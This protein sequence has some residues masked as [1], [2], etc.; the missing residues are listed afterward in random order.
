MREVRVHPVYKGID[1][2]ALWQGLPTLYLMVILGTAALVSTVAPIAMA[3][4]TGSILF[5]LLKW[6]YTW[7]PQFLQILQVSFVKTPR[8]KNS[9]HHGGHYY[10]P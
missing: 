2:P 1:R 9:K 7:E 6:L 5:V 3:L 8:T 4:G 10:D